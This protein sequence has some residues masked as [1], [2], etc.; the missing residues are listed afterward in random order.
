V[1]TAARL[2]ALALLG[3]TLAG[4]GG[5]QA[6]DRGGFTA[7]DRKAAAKALAILG[8]TAVWTTAAKATYTQGFPP[9][10][11]AVHIQSRDPLTFDV[12]MTWVPQRNVN[13]T[14]TWLQAVIGPD[15]V[16]GD[17]K[18]D[19]GNEVT[20][21]ALESHYGTAFS[22]PML[23]CLVLVNRKFGLLPA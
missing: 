21:T 17:Y 19:Y 5:K 10:R 11:C 13:R 16:D 6:V 2:A 23:K 9:T 20:Q 8:D 14:Y 3:L 1:S 4:C 12:L 18:F 15:G 22:K 7:D